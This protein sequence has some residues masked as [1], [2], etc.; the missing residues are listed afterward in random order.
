MSTEFITYV[1]YPVSVAA[2][3]GIGAFLT[4]RLVKYF[5]K[6]DATLVQLT[7]AI[8]LLILDQTKIHAAQD[9]E[10]SLLGEGLGVVKL[11][12]GEHRKDINELFDITDKHRTDIELLKLGK[13][14]K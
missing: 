4:T 1:V 6:L 2:V 13:E 3:V 9:K 12:Q 11:I 8:Q 7:E 10:I 5:N 14:D